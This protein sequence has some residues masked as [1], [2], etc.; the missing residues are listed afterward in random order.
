L[1]RRL[2]AWILDWARTTTRFNRGQTETWPDLEAKATA[3]CGVFLWSGRI[4]GSERAILIQD[5]GVMCNI[6]SNSA[7]LDLNIS[8]E[9]PLAKFCNNIGAQETHEAPPPT[10]VH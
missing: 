4:L 8:R 6:D 7:R 10:S 2:A 5:Q 9:R 1:L 3:T